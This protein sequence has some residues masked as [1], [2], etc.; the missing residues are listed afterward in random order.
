MIYRSMLAY[1]VDD[2]GV[3]VADGDDGFCVTTF[4]RGIP[5]LV[6]PAATSC[7]HD[8]RVANRSPQDAH[9]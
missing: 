8:E 3:I 5:A 7:V 1:P 6:V 4:V 2:V 9:Y